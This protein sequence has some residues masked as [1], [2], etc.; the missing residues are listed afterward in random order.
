MTTYSVVSDSKK[1]L[2]IW[3]V[4]DRLNMLISGGWTRMPWGG[5]MLYFHLSSVLLYIRN[6]TLTKFYVS[7]CMAITIFNSNIFL[8]FYLCNTEFNI[9]FNSNLNLL[10]VVSINYWRYRD[11]KYEYALSKSIYK[12]ITNL[13]K[14]RLQ[15]R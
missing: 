7:T 2:S 3:E 10:S 14:Y 11:N 9:I 13:C 5:I 12:T 6:D 8:G 1:E 15:L 4:E